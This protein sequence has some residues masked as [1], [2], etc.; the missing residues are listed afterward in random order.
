M[1]KNKEIMSWLKNT[2]TKHREK[3]LAVAEMWGRRILLERWPPMKRNGK[4]T[5]DILR[6]GKKEYLTNGIIWE[7]SMKLEPRNSREQTRF[8]GKTLLRSSNDDGKH[9][10]NYWD[11]LGEWESGRVEP[12]MKR[13]GKQS[14]RR[15][16]TDGIHSY[17]PL[18]KNLRITPG[19]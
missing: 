8:R 19:N 14:W 1:Q 3:W 11:T 12:K 9:H 15:H 10:Q 13:I 4:T 17:I 6:M 18:E 16:V 7:D 2:W 5:P